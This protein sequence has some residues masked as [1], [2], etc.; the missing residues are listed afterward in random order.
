MKPEIKEKWIAALI[1]G[2][3]KQTKF[4]LRDQSGFC[5]MGVLCDLY[6]KENDDSWELSCSGSYSVLDE[7]EIIPTAVAEWAGMEDKNPWIMID[8]ELSKVTSLS[9]LNDDEEFKFPEIAQYIAE[10]L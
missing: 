4:R 5:C 1:S 2:D 7:S 6:L 8:S 9:G 10:Q 3:Y